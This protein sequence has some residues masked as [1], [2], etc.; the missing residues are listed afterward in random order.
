MAEH[1]HG[2]PRCETP[3]GTPCTNS[4][5]HFEECKNHGALRSCEASV[6]DGIPTG[7][8]RCLHD[9]KPAMR[10]KAAKAKP[11][12][13]KK[14]AAKPKGRAKKFGPRRH[15]EVSLRR[16]KRR[17]HFY[18]VTCGSADQKKSAASIDFPEKTLLR[19]AEAALE[20]EDCG[21]NVKRYSAHYPKDPDAGRA[22]FGYVRSEAR[23]LE[24]LLGEEL[25]RKLLRIVRRHRRKPRRGATA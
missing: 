13:K 3:A 21:R 17:V 1:L 12:A 22:L 8:Y 23:I 10:A 11:K 19:A 15:F 7:Q 24:K 6:V 20:Y 2:Y 18:T 14:A 5:L 16:E 9:D 4:D 25:Y